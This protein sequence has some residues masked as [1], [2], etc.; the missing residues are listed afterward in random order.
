MPRAIEVNFDGLVGPTHNYAG[1]SYGN[2]ASMAHKRKVSSPR[3]A[4]LQGLAKMRFLVELG[5][6]QA[7]LPPQRRPDLCALRRVGFSGSDADVLAQA[8]REDPVL[9]ASVCSSS[10]MWTAN[11]AT[12]SPSAD[13]ADARVHFTPANLISLFHRSLETASTSAILKAIF[14]DERHFVHHPPLPAIAHFSD[15][16]AANHMRLAKSPGERAAEIFTFGRVASDLTIATAARFPARQTREAGAAIA[17][18]HQLDPNRIALVRQNPAAIDAGAFHNDVVAV[19]N[20]NALFFHEQAFADRAEAIVDIRR[21]LAGELQLL[22]VRESAV[23]LE[24]AI[25]SYLFNSQLVTLPDGTMSLI[26]PIEARENART[27]AYLKDFPFPVHFV[28]VRQSMQ[29]G[30]GPACL[31]LRVLLT[32]AELASA[33]QGV[34]LTDELAARLTA[35]I[36]RHYRD[37]LRA[38][39]LADA[40]L[41]DE[42]EG[43]VDAILSALGL[44]GIGEG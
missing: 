32:E 39:D 9:L 14:A 15:E 20:E 10:S 22:E 35:I 3:Q 42:S 29:N 25:K 7:V 12:I 31:R 43:T 5:V 30:G 44:R 36:Q 26:A 37:E 18:L 38:D 11:A 19:S 21:A 23:P 4:A 33:H 28:D 6:R 17:R 13:S 1:L 40:K 16:G 34:F 8:Q 24:E 27:A 2:V 41:L